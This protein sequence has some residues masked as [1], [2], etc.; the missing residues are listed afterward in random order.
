[1][2]QLSSIEIQRGRSNSSAVSQNWLPPRNDT[3]QTPPAL[4]PTYFDEILKSPKKHY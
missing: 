3:P 2:L 1:M 4:P